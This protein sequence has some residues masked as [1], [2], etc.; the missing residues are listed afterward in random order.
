M[1]DPL[2]NLGWFGPWAMLLTLLYVAVS[3]FIAALS[4]RPDRRRK[5]AEAPRAAVLVAARNEERCLAACL[6]S[7]LAQRYPPDALEIL[8]GDDG[9]TDG[10]AAIARQYAEKHA[11]I[12]VLRVEKQ[13]PGLRGK[14]NVLAQLARLTEAPVLLFA[15][16]D[17]VAPPD[18]A[19][20][21]AAALVQTTVGMTSAPSIVKETGIGSALQALDWLVGTSTLAVGDRID[22]PLTAIGNNMGITREAYDLVGGYEGLPFSITEDFG[23]FVAV[24][25][26]NYSTLFIW[27]PAACSDT[28]AAP[29]LPELVHQRRRWL[30][31][32]LSG[33]WYAVAAYALYQSAPWAALLHWAFGPP[34]GNGLSLVLLIAAADFAVCAAAA[35]AMGRLRLLRWFPLYVPYRLGLQVLVGGSMLLLR[36]VRWKGRLYS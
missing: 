34:D 33:P 29:S 7:L 19:A 6:D 20:T 22:R 31:G 2:S 10:T 5:L 27:N 9:S 11:R 8:V 24:R 4:W 12:R 25:D 36:P 32:G 14:Q 26:W 1:S 30:R 3:A 15:D 17:V 16:A 13:L 23:L 28:W 35:H 21:H 18:W